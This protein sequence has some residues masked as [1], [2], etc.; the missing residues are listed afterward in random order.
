ML[1]LRTPVHGGVAMPCIRCGKITV[2]LC[3]CSIEQ[4]RDAFSAWSDIEL[5]QAIST[6][7]EILEAK[8]RARSRPNVPN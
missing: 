3:S 8:R 4:A 6:L 1:Q 5:E 2:K 7:R